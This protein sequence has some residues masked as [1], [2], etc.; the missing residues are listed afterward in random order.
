[1]TTQLASENRQSDGFLAWLLA[2]GPRERAVKDAAEAH[3]KS[4]AQAVLRWHI[5]HGLIVFPKSVRRER[6]VNAVQDE[7]GGELTEDLKASNARTPDEIRA[8][9]RGV[10]DGHL[11][12]GIAKVIPNKEGFIDHVI[13]PMIDSSFRNQASTTSAMGF[14]QDR[15][16]EQK[17]A[18]DRARGEL[19]TYHVDCVSVLICQIELPQDLMDTQTKKIIAEQLGVTPQFLEGKWDGLIAGLDGKR[20]DVVTG[21]EVTK[22]RITERCYSSMSLDDERAPV[23]Q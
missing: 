17:K 3:G 19:E 8:A 2:K 22:E 12:K 16:E 4:P 23:E 21:A 10:V 15:Q 14:M 20:Y 5:Q 13:H 6:L 7:L 9:W 18:E 11:M 1:M